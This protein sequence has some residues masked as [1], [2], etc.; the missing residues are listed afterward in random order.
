MSLVSLDGSRN[1]P[2]PS[3]IPGQN[4]SVQGPGSAG[5]R[6]EPQGSEIQVFRVPAV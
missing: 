3:Q 1:P 4:P 2:L 6:L 5:D